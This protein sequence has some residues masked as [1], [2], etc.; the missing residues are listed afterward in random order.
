[1]LDLDAAGTIGGRDDL[2]VN[3]QL[4]TLHLI[5]VRVDVGLRMQLQGLA[6]LDLHRLAHC[7]RADMKGEHRPVGHEGSARTDRIKPRVGGEILRS[8]RRTG[9]RQLGLCRGSPNR[10]SG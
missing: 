6:R 9:R 8:A 4:Q 2:P 1:M 5:E 7:G 10:Q 3:H